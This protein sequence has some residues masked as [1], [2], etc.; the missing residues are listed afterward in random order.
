MNVPYFPHPTVQ[1]MTLLEETG[2][3]LQIALALALVNA[4]QNDIGIE[5][6]WVA[7]AD[8][9]TQKEQAN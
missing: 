2:D 7:V 3:D 4:R 8:A 9:L 1:A 5:R 6:Y